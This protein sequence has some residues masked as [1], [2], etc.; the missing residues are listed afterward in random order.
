MD[1]LPGSIALSS[2]TLVLLLIIP[3][4]LSKSLYL[5]Y[6]QLCVRRVS[7]ATQISDKLY[8]LCVSPQSVSSEYAE[9]SE[10]APGKIASKL[11]GTESISVTS[12]KPPRDRVP[13]T[14]ED[15]Q[16]AYECGNFEGTKPSELFLRC[17]HDALLALEHDPLNGCVSP[18]LMGSSGVIPLTVVGSIVDVN[19]HMSNLIARAEHEVFLATNFWM[20]SDSS[21]LIVDAIRE[22]SRRIG[23]K[24]T[25][26]KAVVKIM[27][28]RGH[29]K[30]L[31]DPHTVVPEKEYTGK[32]VNL[33][34]A[35]EIPHVDL[36]VMNYHHPMLGTFHCKFMVVDRRIAVVNSNN[37]QSND[38]C[39]MATHLEGK[40][41]DSLWDLS[42][43]SWDRALKPPLPLAN[44]PV[45]KGD[46]PSFGEKSFIDL[47]DSEGKLKMPVLHNGDLSKDGCKEQDGA[48]PQESHTGPHPHFDKDIASEISRMQSTLMPRGNE[49]KMD[50][51][52]K[53][54]SKLVVPILVSAFHTC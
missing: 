32:A 4:V 47:F 49:T 2:L 8:R 18:S 36:Q 48:E 45:V 39:E 30:Q 21:L 13:A 35:H 27:Y 24:G 7:M 40:I 23:R 31:V 43:L 29:I 10:A 19:R 5:L 25:G 42:L 12:P 44:K 1:S 41:V 37:I 28:D 3:S 52:A 22:L 11:Y 6:A 14:V 15:L 53:H 20:N 9:G 26:E 50:M 38:N 51:V 46:C 33:P 16:R 54:L 34:Y 17:Y